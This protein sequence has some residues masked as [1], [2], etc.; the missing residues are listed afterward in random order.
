M[1]TCIVTGA[2]DRFY[3]FCTGLLESLEDHDSLKHDLY[4]IDCGLEFWQ[5][6]T[7]ENSYGAKI[8]QV[9]LGFGLKSS[10]SYLKTM[11]ARPYLP[12]L[13]PGYEAYFYID[14]DTMVLQPGVVEDFLSALSRGADIA[15][16]QERSPSY[17]AHFFKSTAFPLKTID[18]QDINFSV[19]QAF[20]G[21]NA[22][23]F[24]PEEAEFLTAF[25]CI[26]SGV[27]VAR[28]KS[29]LW[30]AWVE[31]VEQILSH[32]GDKFG[33]KGIDVLFEQSALN[34]AIRQ[35]AT[36]IALYL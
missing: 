7:L 25:D 30:Q 15:C 13:I 12:T 5:A 32:L 28:A 36:Q 4:V 19:T 33:E 34:K 11:T 23:F 29:P 2:D 10:F 9:P 8:I 24:S 31:N 27:F 21:I 26:N 1:K 14:A 35:G 17:S 18:R 16:I 22:R 20:S 6:Q 3:E